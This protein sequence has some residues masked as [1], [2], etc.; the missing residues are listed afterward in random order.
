M[1]P[2]DQ[3]G[4]PSP[5]AFRCFGH[6]FLLLLCAAYL[7]IPFPSPNTVTFNGT[8]FLSSGIKAPGMP[9][10]SGTVTAAPGNYV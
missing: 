9:D 5:G 4:A 2:F 3:H 1:G 6:A 7:G 8:N 10:Y